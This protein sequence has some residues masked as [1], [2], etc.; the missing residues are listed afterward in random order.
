MSQKIAHTAAGSILGV[1]QCYMHDIMIASEQTKDDL[2]PSNYAAMKYSWTDLTEII[3]GRHFDRLKRSIQQER[4]YRVYTSKLKRNWISIHDYILHT[5][6]N[7]DI[8]TVPQNTRGNLSCKNNIE[9]DGISSDECTSEMRRK[10]LETPPPGCRLAAT[11]PDNEASFVPERLIVKNNFSYYLED[12]IEH[13]VL[14]KLGDLTLIGA[15]H[16]CEI[17][18][19][20]KK[21]C[22]GSTLY[23]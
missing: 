15:S 4:I 23:I 11:R 16:S 5:K 2:D 6:F 7:Y 13:W 18:I 17:K 9:P 12:G 14:W 21:Y 22:H 19:P 10:A 3:N 1:Y 8:V 20:T